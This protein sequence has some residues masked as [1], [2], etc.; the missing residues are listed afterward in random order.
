[1]EAPLVWKP[2]RANETFGVQRCRFAHISYRHAR[3]GAGGQLVIKRGSRCAGREEQIA[4]KA[5]KIASDAFV[6]LDRLNAIY[7]GGLA[8]INNSRSI[9]PACFD[10]VGITIV[11]R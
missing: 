3:F 8:L 2:Q 4:I 10:Q 9:E 5:L 11:Q 7:R 1:M 6:R